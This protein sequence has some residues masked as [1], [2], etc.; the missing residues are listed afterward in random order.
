MQT[1]L[2]IVFTFPRPAVPESK[3]RVRIFHEN[4]GR[5]VVVTS[6]IPGS[7]GTSMT[8]V[9]EQVATE[10]LRRFPE[11]FGLTYCEN[12]AR[13]GIEPIWIEY[14]PKGCLDPDFEELIRSV[15]YCFK[16]G[17]FTNPH[18]TLTTLE[19]IKRQLSNGLSLE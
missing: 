13:L 7:S 1:V 16:D 2:D 6:H 8:N 3:C 18:W 10:L 14:Y 4:G 12:F 9:S 5:P 17:I 19:D 15:T 11:C